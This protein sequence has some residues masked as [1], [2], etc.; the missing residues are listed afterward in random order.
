MKKLIIILTIVILSS[1]RS[2]QIK[3]REFDIKVAQLIETGYTLKT[4][5][6][7]AKVELGYTKP[8][9]EYNAL[10]ED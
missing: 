10:M 5:V 9:K 2:S 8:N 7:I 6:L 1:C 3:S 4:A